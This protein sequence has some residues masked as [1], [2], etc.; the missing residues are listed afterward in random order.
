MV[1]CA[2]PFSARAKIQTNARCT[3]Q[4]QFFLLVFYMYKGLLVAQ[5]YADGAPQIATW[6]AG[7]RIGGVFFDLAIC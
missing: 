3:I 4:W 2:V 6:L 1:L 5:A 7:L